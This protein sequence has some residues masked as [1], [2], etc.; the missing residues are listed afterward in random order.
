M[1]LFLTTL[2]V[3]LVSAIYADTYYIDFENGN[4]DN[5]GL[6]E[7]TAW[8]NA[9][10]IN[11]KL[12]NPGDQI[13]LKRGQSWDG[14]ISISSN[15]QEGMPILFGAYGSG[16][17]PVIYGMNIGGDFIIVE[18][19]LIDHKKDDSD[20]VILSS[21]KN[22]TL[23]NLELKNGLRDAIDANK[24]DNFLLEG[25]TIHH[26]LKSSFSNQEDAHGLVLT[27]TKNITV[28][29][30]EIYQISGDCIQ[31]DP[32]R[33]TDTPDNLLIEDCHLWTGPLIE[34]FNSGWKTGNTPGENALDTKLVKDNWDSIDRMR[35][36]IKNTVA[37]G[38]KNGNISNM[39]A[40]NLKEKIEAVLDGVT[41]YDS[42]I[43]FRLRGARGNANV[44]IMNALVYDCEY[45]I[46][47]EDDVAELKLYN[48]TFGNGIETMLTFAGGDGGIDSWEILNNAFIGSKPELA[49]HISNKIAS[50]LDFE[51]D[52]NHEY[53]LKES[54]GLIDKGVEISLVQNDRDGNVRPQGLG[55]DIGAFEFDGV[56]TNISIDD[57]TPHKTFTL[58]QNYPNPFNPQTTIKYLVSKAGK[59]SLTIFSSTGQLV[60]ELV[61]KTLMPGNYSSVWN[62]KNLFGNKVAAGM[63][64]Y[65]LVSSGEAETKKMILIP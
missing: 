63:Y 42:E 39:A 54:S 59:V 8:K 18:N 26:F 50:T 62:G 36:T 25:S 43:A 16:E 58:K 57:F 13:L 11:D 19:M 30:T 49:S 34:D 52:T 3:T 60:K 35:I 44:T 6:N 55:Y 17:N 28:R 46:R 9:T 29:N 51:A 65:R 21:A 15:G 61:N 20:C 40:F 32:D 41:I 24:A 14:K 2:F 48:S 37:N 10:I 53:Y 38:W 33:D 45:A 31:T 7:G 22:V 5:T 4:D 64:H 47:A 27:D 12:F 56:A 23:R 1:K